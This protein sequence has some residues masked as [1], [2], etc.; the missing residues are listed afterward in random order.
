MQGATHLPYIVYTQ[1]PENLRTPCK[2]RG[3]REYS[4]K[5]TREY[6]RGVVVNLPKVY[7]LGPPGSA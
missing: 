6:P 3:A 1:T 2:P 5:C 7:M 4:S